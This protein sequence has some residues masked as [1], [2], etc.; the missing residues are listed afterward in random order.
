MNVLL[1]TVQPRRSR[2]RL[3]AFFVALGVALAT[4]SI[5]LGMY[6]GIAQELPATAVSHRAPQ[7]SRYHYPIR[8]VIFIIKENRSFDNLFGRF[9]GA[10]GA[11]TGLL[12]TGQRVPLGHMPDSFL[13]DIGHDPSS[14][15]LAVD[16]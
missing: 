4:V 2:H 10:D 6:P 3:V 7:T 1:H 5:A 14:V 9:P 8:H 13:F 11:T 12:S 16:G 15:H